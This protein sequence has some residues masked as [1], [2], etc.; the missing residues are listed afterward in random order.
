MISPGDL[1]LFHR[2]NSVDEAY[3]MIIKGLTENALGTPGPVL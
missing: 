3:Q 2:T 1:A